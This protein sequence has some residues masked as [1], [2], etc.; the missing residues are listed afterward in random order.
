MPH[1]TRPDTTPTTE[2]YLEIIYMMAAEDRIV[3]GARLAEIIGVS[4]PTVTATLRRMLRDDLIALDAKKQITLTPKGYAIA[5]M[6][7]RRH[8][9]IERWLTDTLGLDWAESDAESHRLE[10]V[11][12]D[13]VVERLNELL[14]FPETCPHGNPIPGNQRGEPSAAA[15]PLSQAPEGARLLVARISEYVENSGEMLKHLGGR[16]L[17]PGAQVTVVEHSPLNQAL[18]LRVN[19]KHFALALEIANALWVTKG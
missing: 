9:I 3:K 4:R 7:Q 6:L 17:V 11:F 15:F 12:S 14:G 13:Q 5:D 10:H 19:D 16:G 8:R 2:E 18:T 1:S